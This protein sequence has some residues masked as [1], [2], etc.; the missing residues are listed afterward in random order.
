M[1]L[2]SIFKLC[3]ENL[4]EYEKKQLITML[5]KFMISHPSNIEAEAI[6]NKVIKQI[7]E[8]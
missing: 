3:I 5:S 2:E 7:I 6:Y 4:A 8:Q 1:N